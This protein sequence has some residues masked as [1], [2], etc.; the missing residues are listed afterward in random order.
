MLTVWLRTARR[1]MIWLKRWTKP[2]R[3][4]T[5]PAHPTNRLPETDAGCCVHIDCPATS[6][7]LITD[8]PVFCLTAVACCQA[9]S[10]VQYI[11]I[12]QKTPHNLTIWS[13]FCTNFDYLVKKCLIFLKTR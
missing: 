11:T 12:S 1:R 4:C 9:I 10:F 2:I 8:F 7:T 13:S 5:S 3:A 6:H